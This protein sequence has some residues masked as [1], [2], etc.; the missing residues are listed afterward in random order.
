MRPNTKQLQEGQPVTTNPS[1]P[2]AGTVP[3]RPRGKAA[4]GS[5]CRLQLQ[6]SLK[7]ICILSHQSSLSLLTLDHGSLWRHKKKQKL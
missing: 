1:P 2:L 5:L 7:L 3:T 4:N 6:W